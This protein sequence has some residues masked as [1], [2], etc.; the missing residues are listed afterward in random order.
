MHP[1]GSAECQTKMADP[2]MDYSMKSSFLKREQL[3][4]K[5]MDPAMSFYC[6]RTLLS[7][8]EH[9]QTEATNC[10]NG[11]KLQRSIC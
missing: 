10:L 5:K 9:V 4:D 8:T 11:L 1:L 7:F 6:V 2:V 3:I